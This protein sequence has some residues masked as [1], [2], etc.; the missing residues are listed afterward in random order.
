[1]QKAFVPL[2]S[3]QKAPGLQQ[4]HQA[5]VSRFHGAATVTGDGHCAARL[6][7]G[8]ARGT[9]TWSALPALPQGSDPRER[10]GEKEL[11]QIAQLFAE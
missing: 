11:S 7:T 8:H 1:L 2:Q 3:Q 9:G 10:S 4:Q 6:V 5:L